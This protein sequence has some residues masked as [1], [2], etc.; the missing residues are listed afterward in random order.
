MVG[1]LLPTPEA[2]LASSGPDYARMK[3]EGSGGHDLSTAIAIETDW[4]SYAEAI[5]R[6]ESV[7]GRLAPSP[8][9]LNSKGNPRLSA[10]FVEWLMMLPAGWV[11]DVPGLSRNQ[12]LKALGNGVVPAQ[13]VAA[14]SD[15]LSWSVAA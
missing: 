1:R 9:E 8:T 5:R 13:A 7:L 14:F 4:G 12:M 6:H 15:L 3:R 10:P 11:T 2:K